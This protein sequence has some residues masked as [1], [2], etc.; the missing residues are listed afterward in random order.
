MNMHHHPRGTGQRHRG[1]SLLE[2]MIAISLGLV[3]IAAMLSVYLSSKSAFRRTEEL[4]SLQSSAR[5]A[6]EYMGFD[7]RAAGMLGCQAGAD[8]IPNISMPPTMVDGYQVGVEGFDAATAPTFSSTG[9]TTPSTWTANIAAGTDISST[10]T[11]ASIVFNTTGSGIPNAITEGSDV[12]VLRG[13]SVSMPLRLTAL[14]ASPTDLVPESRRD[15]GTVCAS[16]SPR[17]T[18][19]SAGSHVLVT[20]CTGARLATVATAVATVAPTSSANGKT[21]LTLS[22]TGTT[23]IGVLSLDTT[24]VFPVQTVIYYV[25]PSDNNS[26]TQS[27]FRHVFSGNG[28]ANAGEKQELIEGVEN[29]QVLYGVD[30]TAD[31]DGDV[32]V[33]QVASDVSSW[34]RVLSV[35]ISI[36][37][38]PSTPLGPGVSS[39]AS[40]VVGDETVTFPNTQFDRRVFTTTL[41]LRNK[42]QFKAAS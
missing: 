30:T 12:L 32:D 39:A 14:P 40:S 33:Y 1:F 31:V 37:M 29:M 42:L 28:N 22:G 19:F 26:A 10:G 41:M 18:C 4:S 3:A 38:R 16:G 21:T 9:V 36:L 35:R 34:E 17:S 7:S 15:G 8:T 11:T 25:A 24:E 20:N 5:T 27:L 2:M 23:G 13:P 6:F